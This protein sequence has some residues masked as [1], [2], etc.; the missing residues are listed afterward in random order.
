MKREELKKLV[1]YKLFRMAAPTSRLID[2]TRKYEM[3]EEIKK[4]EKEW[5]PKVEE[6]ESE[7]EILKKEVKEFL[8]KDVDSVEFL[9]NYKC[10][11]QVRITNYDLR[12]M[13]SETCIFCGRE[14]YNTN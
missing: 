2:L 14:F 10:N 8:Q 6:L 5:F 11:H 12:F 9:K 1:E 13:K 3:N 7:F 4:E